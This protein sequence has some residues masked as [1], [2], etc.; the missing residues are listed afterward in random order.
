MKAG[1]K[2]GHSV[3]K[4]ISTTKMGHSVLEKTRKKIS[5]AQKGQHHSPNTEFK[6]GKTSWNK[7]KK[8]PPKSIEWRKKQSKRIDLQ[9]KNHYNWKGG[10]TPEHKLFRRGIEY[11]LWRESVFERDNFTC[12]VCGEKGVYLESHHI[13]SFANFPE[14]RLAIDNGQTL[15]RECH[16]LTDNYRGRNKGKNI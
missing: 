12:Q 14:L 10:V 3:R 8:M 5:I 9:G 1:E 2:M 15:C 7:G 4:K 11:K 16:K 13:K 6:K